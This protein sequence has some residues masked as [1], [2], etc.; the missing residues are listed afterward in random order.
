[1]LVL[2]D[3]TALTLIYISQE[4]KEK[5]LAE[6]R[7]GTTINDRLLSEIPNHMHRQYSPRKGVLHVKGWP[8][9]AVSDHCGGPMDSRMDLGLP[10]VLVR[11]PCLVLPFRSHTTARA[12]PACNHFIFS[13]Q[14][15]RQCQQTP[16]ISG[17]QRS[18][19][20]RFILARIISIPLDVINVIRWACKSNGIRSH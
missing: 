5:E 16:Q 2:Y 1:M 20:L 4:Y 11:S 3:L 12:H 14:F 9:V 18:A 15:R 13:F 6:C 10:V 8:P 19:R 17:Q 7:V